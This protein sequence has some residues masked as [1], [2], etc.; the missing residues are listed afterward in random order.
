M[1]CFFTVDTT[2]Q[3]VP[4]DYPLWTQS[5][6][7]RAALIFTVATKQRRSR[8]THLSL[9]LRR[10]YAQ[11]LLLP[12]CHWNLGTNKVAAPDKHHVYLSLP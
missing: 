9:K 2:N 1:R 6:Q 10:K 11:Q 7:G 4:G 5:Q 3:G 8:E 12:H